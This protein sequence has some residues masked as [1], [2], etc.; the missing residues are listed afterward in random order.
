M[1]ISIYTKHKSSYINGMNKLPLNTR[2][3][4]LTLLCEGVSMRS[5]TRIAD[6]SINTVSKLLVDTGKFCADLHDR[7]VRN[8]KAQHVQC[9][10]IWSFTAAKQKNVAAMKKPVEG[11]G[12]TWTWTALDRDSKLIISYLVGGRDGEY[13]MAFIDDVKERLAN[14]VQLTTDGHKA[15]LEAV[16]AAFGADIDYVMLVKMYGEPTGAGSE[17]RYSPNECTGARKVKISGNPIKSQVS[18][19][20][21]ERQN[22]TMRMQMRRF[23]RLTNGFSKKFENHMHMVALY[24][25]WYNFIRIHKTLKMSPAMAAGVS[26]TLW[27]MNELCEKMD[28]V[29]PKPGRRGPYKKT[30]EEISN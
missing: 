24:T 27:S 19:S 7:E 16:E 14:R 20:H 3:Q 26:K 30:A 9:D 5:I 11:A 28:L 10:E 12:D 13:A 22:L 29:A 23:T 17:R 15:Y 21:V 18:T 6:V 1:K 8:V 25:V 4:I 2:A